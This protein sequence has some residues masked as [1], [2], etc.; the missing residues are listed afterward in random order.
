MQLRGK[1]SEESLRKFLEEE[2]LNKYN[3]LFQQADDD[4]VS[5]TRA[6]LSL[7]LLLM[8]NSYCYQSY[9]PLIK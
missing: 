6:H 7:L 5:V 3:L 2:V 4:L 1:L 9:R 8:L